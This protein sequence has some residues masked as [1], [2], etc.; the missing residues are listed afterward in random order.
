MRGFEITSTILEQELRSAMHTFD[1]PKSKLNMFKHVAMYRRHILSGI[2]TGRG[3]SHRTSMQENMYLGGDKCL[4]GFSL[5]ALQ[6][7]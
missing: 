6:Y 2:I 3:I 7:H 4:G 1:L 5:R